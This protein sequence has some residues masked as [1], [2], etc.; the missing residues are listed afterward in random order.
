MW[1][2]IYCQLPLLACEY[3]K[4]AFISLISSHLFWPYLNWPHF[5]WI[6]RHWVCHESIQFAGRRSR[7]LVWLVAAMANWV[8]SQCTHCHSVHM[9]EVSWDVVRCD[10]MRWVIRTLPKL[11][12]LQTFVAANIE[13]CCTAW[14]FHTLLQHVCLSVH[15]TAVT[16]SPL[17]A[18]LPISPY[19]NLHHK[20]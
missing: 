15:Y 13:H 20:M 8:T 16:V 10:E 11:S 18:L 19:S 9:N 3:C 4:G 14:R 5:V 6:E 1:T 17:L 2:V 12:E 7:C